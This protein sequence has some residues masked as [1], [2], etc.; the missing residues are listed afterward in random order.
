MT[1][2]GAFKADNGYDHRAGTINLNFKK[3]AQVR[4]RVHRFVIRRFPD[5]CV[6]NYTAADAIANTLQIR[7][8]EKPV[9]NIIERFAK[10]ENRTS[11]DACVRT[12]A[13]MKTNGSIAPTIAAE[14]KIQIPPI[15]WAATIHPNW[16]RKNRA[17]QTD[18]AILNVRVFSVL[19]IRLT[20]DTA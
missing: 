11:P 8:I 16:T 20:H 13:R 18:N 5:S 1:L 9:V 6:H 19:G 17:T 12:N 4:L 15:V 10:P 2:V 7:I 3:H 14:S